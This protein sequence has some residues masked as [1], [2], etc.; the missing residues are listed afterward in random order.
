MVILRIP[1]LIATTSIVMRT[2]SLVFMFIL[3]EDRDT[4]VNSCIC[5]ISDEE[6][7]WEKS[8]KTHYYM[9]PTYQDILPPEQIGM[10]KI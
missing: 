5:L 9:H 3:S 8:M 10:A 6:F 4:V 1:F 7:R 2:S